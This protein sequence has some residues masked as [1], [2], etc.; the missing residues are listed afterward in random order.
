M[1]AFI[2]DLVELIKVGVG[3]E[4]EAAVE[5][6]GILGNLN[7]PELD[8]GKI[9]HDLQLAPFLMSRLRVCMYL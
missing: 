2:S 6:V 4:E 3:E 5:A 8:F 9:M 1:Q 7:I